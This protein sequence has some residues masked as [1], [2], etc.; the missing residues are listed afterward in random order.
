MAKTHTIAIIGAGLAGMRLAQL[1]QG[2]ATVSVFEKSRGVGGRMSTRRADPFSFDHG[3]Q[4]FSAQTVEFKEFLA[5][6]IA[7][8]VVQPW[9][10]RLM[11]LPYASPVP[12]AWSSPRYVAVPGMT[13]LAKALDADVG[14]TRGSHID[15]LQG[16]AGHW[17]LSDREGGVF[18]PFDWVISTAPAIQTAALLPRNMA[19]RA[20][21]DQARMRGCYSVMIGV[22]DPVITGWDAA[23]VGQGPLAWI[24]VNSSKPGRASASQSIVA[25]TSNVWAAA[26]LERDQQAVQAELLAAFAHVTGHDVSQAAYTSLHRWRYANVDVPSGAPFFMDPQAGLAAAGDWCGTGKVEAAFISASTLAA[27]LVN[28]IVNARP[29][30]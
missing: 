25:Q 1:L 29:V 23:W 9:P 15:G 5:P 4:Y 30:A 22:D 7:K 27:A 3:A 6:L 19:G 16:R 11:S 13:A 12:P 18:G 21:L 8:G 17:T 2:V 28:E 20:A 26:N 24:A 10:A 14:V